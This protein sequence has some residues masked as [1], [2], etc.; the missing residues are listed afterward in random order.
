MLPIYRDELIGICAG[1]QPSSRVEHAMCRFKVYL[2]EQ[3]RIHKWDTVRRGDGSEAGS[4]IYCGRD[5]TGK[6][7]VSGVIGTVLIGIL[8]WVLVSTWASALI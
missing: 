7:S 6:P 1:R 5:L 2:S 8:I 4:I 3:R